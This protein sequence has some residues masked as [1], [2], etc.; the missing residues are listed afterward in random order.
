MC[1]APGSK[2]SQILEMMHLQAQQMENNF[3]NNLSG[4]ILANDIK[5]QRCN[6]LITQTKRLNSPCI[7]VTYHEAQIFPSLFHP[8]KKR[9]IMFDR[10]LCDV[11]C[12]GDGT[13]RKVYNFYYF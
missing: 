3:Y 12:S 6:T 9:P 8:I 10:I 13:L 5:P 1:A 11:P 2:T 4:V 7:I